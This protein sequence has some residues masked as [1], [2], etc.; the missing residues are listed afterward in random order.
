[1]AEKPRRVVPVRSIITSVLEV[2]GALALTVAGF[3]AFGVAGLLAVV[4]GLCF[5]LSYALTRGSA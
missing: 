5:G 1:M 3:L 4:G 2:A